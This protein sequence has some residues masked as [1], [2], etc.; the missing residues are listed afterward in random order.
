[1]R[2]P[3]RLGNLSNVGTA[4]YVIGLMLVLVGVASQVGHWTATLA[5]SSQ[6]RLPILAGGVVIMGIGWL[7]RKNSRD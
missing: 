7:V 6:V 3:V 1:M 2:S 5:L 4:L